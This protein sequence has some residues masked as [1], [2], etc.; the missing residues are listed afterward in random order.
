MHWGECPECG[1][2]RR[3]AGDILKPHRRY[4]GS[5]GGGVMVDCPGA[6]QVARPVVLLPEDDE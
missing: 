4:L 2:I 5:R 1:R 6:N 3:I